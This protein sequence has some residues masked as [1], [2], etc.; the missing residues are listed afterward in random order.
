MNEKIYQNLIFQLDRLAAH[1]R[2][3]SFQTRRRYYEAMKRFC[4]FL[5][6]EYHVERLAN[7]APKHIFAYT[8]SMQ[9]QGK[10]AATIKTDLAAIRFFHDQMPNPRYRL[11][12]NNALIL[13]CRSFGKVDRTWSDAEFSRM[14][15]KALAVNRYDYILALHL[16]RYAGLRIHE[17]FRIDTA[18]A[19]KALRDNAITVKGKGGKIRTVPINESISLALRMQLERTKLGHKLLVPDGVPTDQAIH[20]LQEFLIRYRDEVKDTES[21]CPL[22]FHGLR[23]SFAAERYRELVARGISELEAH[24]TVSQ[25]LGHNRADVTNVYLASLKK[26]S[27]TSP[28]T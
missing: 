12:E 25:L 27:P 7:I 14:Q 1:N 11:P 18:T 16:A 19:K 2:Q 15:A 23:H 10:S 6:N 5:T 28:S 26:Q 4:K 13:E 22:T 24:Y 17:C 21:C 9:A 20:Q 8:K 3:G